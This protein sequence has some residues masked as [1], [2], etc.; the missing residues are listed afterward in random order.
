MPY[1]TRRKSNFFSNY[2]S[3]EVEKCIVRQPQAYGKF[4]LLQDMR[5]KF[6]IKVLKLIR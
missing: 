5:K 1:Y 6:K 4:V 2:T 3:T